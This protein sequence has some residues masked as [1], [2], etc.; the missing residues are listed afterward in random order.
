M[1]WLEEHLQ[2]L[3][4]YIRDLSFRKAMIAYIL[5]LAAV[6][7]VL[8][9]LTM[10]V[11][12]Q[13]EMAE[14]VRY[15]SEELAELIGR[16]GPL[17]GFW[18]PFA[19]GTDSVKVLFLD[20]LRVWCPFFYS[21]AGM[22]ITIGIFY[23]KRLARPLSIL[24]DSVE[25]IRGNDLAFRVDYES[26]DELGSLCD[27]VE[28]MRAELVRGKEEMW[29][30]V[31]RQKELNAAFAHDLRT[32]LTVLRGYTDFLARYLPEGKI[33]EEKMQDTLALMSGYLKRLENY[34]RTMKGIQS[35]EEVPFSPEWM[36]LKGIQKKIEEVVF[37]LNQVGDVK[38]HCRRW[39]G[40]DGLK[41]EADD[42]IIMEVLENVLSNAIRY[43]E[44]EIEIL[45]DYEEE[46]MEFLLTIR[47]DGA[48]FSEEQLKKALQPYHK[49]YEGGEMDEHFGIGLHICREF[50][51]K[52]GGTLNVANSIQGG[53][54]VTASFSCISAKSR[55]K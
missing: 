21:F 44:E 50:C 13:W 45:S 23:R 31:E 3:Q 33:S 47:D 16:K 2:N 6:V 55:C 38:I 48:G 43:A 30:L 49:E 14:W 51:R 11:C 25:K 53:A 36:E 28:E 18:Y 24:A 34:S 7:S 5:V 41:V 1:D 26:R 29:R 12:W 54:V 8:S 35:I 10:I 15:E 32:P 27:S 9:Y 42:H 22:I 40:N 20:M 39:R 46:K 4:R 37:A 19:E 17:W 52:H